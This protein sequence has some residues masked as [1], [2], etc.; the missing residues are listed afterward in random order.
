[1]TERTAP[2]NVV[3]AWPLDSVI[4]VNVFFISVLPS[5]AY[6]QRSKRLM[7]DFRQFEF[8]NEL[9]RCLRFR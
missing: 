5:R 6:R 4:A 3:A 9:Q 7:Y 2:L 1:M 8:T